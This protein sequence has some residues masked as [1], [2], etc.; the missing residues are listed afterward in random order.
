MFRLKQMTKL[1]KS[2]THMQ[3]IFFANENL[4]FAIA[5]MVP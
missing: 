5:V 4:L 1:Q 3:V 2:K